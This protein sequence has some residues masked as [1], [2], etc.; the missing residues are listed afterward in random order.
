MEEPPVSFRMNFSKTE[1]NSIALRIYK[2]NLMLADTEP[3]LLCSF[4]VHFANQQVDRS[5][6]KSPVKKMMT[7]KRSSPPRKKVRKYES[8]SSESSSGSESE[9]DESSSS[10]SEEEDA[11]GSCDVPGCNAVLKSPAALSSH[12]KSEHPEHKSGSKT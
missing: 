11:V 3:S 9:T 5:R 10:E 6:S 8:S 1:E 2:E 7:S 12:M 4:C